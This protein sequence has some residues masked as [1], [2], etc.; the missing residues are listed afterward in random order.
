MLKNY[1]KTAWRNLSKNKTSSIINISGLAVGMA[2]AIL[3][4]LWI[5]DELSFNKSFQNYDHIAQVLTNANYNGGINTDYNS[6]PPYGDELRNNF[7]SD[8]KHVL[9]TSRPL[10]MLLSSGE[11]KLMK[12]GYYFEP[13]ISDMINLK[14]V[15][16][17][18]DGL[19]D[20]SS[21]LLSESLAKAFY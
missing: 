13:G 14:M 18:R 15:K 1:F 5:W 21:I 8:F 6:A 3:I 16:G 12:N 7:G 2:V 11:K 9:M 20:P 10:K 19:K 4:G 17:S